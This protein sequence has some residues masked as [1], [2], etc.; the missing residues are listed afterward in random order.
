MANNMVTVPG[1]KMLIGAATNFSL[2][3]TTWSTIWSKMAETWTP[4]EALA[5]WSVTANSMIAPLFKRTEPKETETGDA[6]RSN[7]TIISVTGAHGGPGAPGG[8]RS[9]NLLFHDNKYTGVPLGNPWVSAWAVRMGTAFQPW[10]LADGA[11][12]WD[13]NDPHGLYA[14]GTAATASVVDSETKGSTSF[15]VSWKFERIQYG[16]I[17]YPKYS[18]RVRGYHSFCCL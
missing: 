5:M 17:L 2:R 7:S 16:R 11:N 18:Y 1:R 15:Y 4:K 8:L 10:K 14:S 9:G 6:G 12:P 3:K 13:Q